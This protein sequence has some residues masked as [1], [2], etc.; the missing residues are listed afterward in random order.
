MALRWTAERAHSW[1]GISKLLR[2]VNYLPRTAVN[3]TEMWQADTFDDATIEQ[4]LAWAARYGYTSVRV[5]LTYLVWHNDPA[6]TIARFDRFLSIAETRGISVMPVLFDD[7]AF[8]VGRA[9]YAGPQDD[10][11]PGVHNSRRVPSPGP[12]LVLDRNSWDTLA[13][14][15]REI[16][17]PFAADTRVVAWDVYNEP[18]NG[19]MNE[20]SMP[21]L[22]ATFEWAREVNP[23]QP[24]TVGF[25]RGGT[26]AIKTRMM[27]LS[28][29]V[30]FHCYSGPDEL[31]TTLGTALTQDRPAICTEWLNRG[32]GNT[33]AAILPIFEEHGVGWYHWDLVS[34]RTQTAL[35]WSSKPG[36]PP[37]A[38]WQHDVLHPDG[39]PYDSAEME[40]VRARRAAQ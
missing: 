37:P 11:V 9:P 3:A 27:E 23:M 8:D 24:L 20:T 14:Y 25:W 39:T 29:V 26:D 13:T 34:G 32:T 5:F 12:Q 1:R 15:V 33:F 2:G 4:E 17:G 22:E 21:L 10:P 28:D 36:D 18:G 38:I 6:G 19:G 35:P 7:C 40:L 16:V 30:S 31:R